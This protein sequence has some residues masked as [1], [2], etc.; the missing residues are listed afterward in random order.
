M[1]SQKRPSKRLS[2]LYVYITSFN[3][4]FR[5]VVIQS[6]DLFNG[7]GLKLVIEKGE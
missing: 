2:K 7:L 6:Y 5:Y 1:V 4:S 3:S